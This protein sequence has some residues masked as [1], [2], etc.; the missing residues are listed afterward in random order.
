MEL[1]RMNDC[2]HTMSRG[3]YA[4]ADRDIMEA[5]MARLKEQSQS[6]PAAL[7]TPPSPIRREDR[8]KFAHQTRS[9]QYTSER[10]REIGEQIVS[11]Q[12]D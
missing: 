7:D 10:A 2:P 3:G 6:D 12:N 1:G 8:W 4:K 5:K 9:G 11:T